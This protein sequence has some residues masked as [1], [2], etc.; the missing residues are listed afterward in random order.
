M[1]Y[2]NVTFLVIIAAISRGHLLLSLEVIQQPVPRSISL[3]VL[4]HFYFSYPF[5]TIYIYINV[6][7]VIII[8]NSNTT[9][10]KT[11][12]K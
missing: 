5:N 11:A 4:D 6:V 8:V 10:I 9:E 2:L 3:E 7:V 12:N 1:Y